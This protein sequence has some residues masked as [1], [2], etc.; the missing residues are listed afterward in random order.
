MEPVV[1][2]TA[3]TAAASSSKGKEVAR[4]PATASTSSMVPRRSKRKR[5]DENSAAVEVDSP[6]AEADSPAFEVD[7]PA[8]EVDIPRTP[9][10]KKPK[11]TAEEVEKAMVPPKRFPTK[12]GCG[13]KFDQKTV[14]GI[15]AHFAS[16]YS[17]A[18]KADRE[19]LPCRWGKCATTLTY[20]E[21]VRHC[22]IDHIGARW[23]CPDC[24]RL[25]T[26]PNGV[27][28]HK[29]SARACVSGL[30]FLSIVHNL[31]LCFCRGG[32]RKG[33]CEGHVDSVRRFVTKVNGFGERSW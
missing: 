8:F 1:G 22:K 11:M 13:A 12:C 30:G 21:L 9:T 20:G 4:E 28:R 15:V 5:G 18:E 6:A 32:I 3:T 10:S 14:P 27:T 26:R 31:T 19:K 24:D 29:Q 23:P 2:T 16:H 17:V 33:G 7:S 25:F